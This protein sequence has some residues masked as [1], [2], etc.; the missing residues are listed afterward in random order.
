MYALQNSKLRAIPFGNKK[1]EA[2]TPTSHLEPYIDL[3]V[4][5]TD[6]AQ[7]THRVA[8][9]P[10]H[11]PSSRLRLGRTNP[12]S[13]IHVRIRRL[14]RDETDLIWWLHWTSK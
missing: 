9:V 1:L 13:S 7:R 5:F 6:I 4:R 8:S 3:P 10:R 12:D 14:R 11:L 2:I